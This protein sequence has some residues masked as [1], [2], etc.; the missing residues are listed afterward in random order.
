MPK[1]VTI[2]ERY[3]L[4]TRQ[5]Q[6]V[7]AVSDDPICMSAKFDSLFCYVATETDINSLR[8]QLSVYCYRIL[9][10][11]VYLMC[12]DFYVLTVYSKFLT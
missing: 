2:A 10:V 8:R 7:T 6:T 9:Q 11:K 5:R 4:G 3:T 12:D 1:I